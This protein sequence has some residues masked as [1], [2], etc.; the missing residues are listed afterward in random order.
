MRWT[1]RQRAMLR[2]MGVQV[3]SREPALV[4]A[5]PADGDEAEATSARRVSAAAKATAAAARS[6]ASPSSPPSPKGTDGAAVTA[7]DWLVVGDPLDPNDPQQELLLDNLLRAIGVSRKA[8]ARAGRAVFVDDPADIAA[9]IAS[10]APRCVIAL[11]RG[12][13]TA[14]LGRDEPVG[15]WRGR[16]HRHGDVPVVVTFALAF[17]LRHPA[18]KAKAWLDLC[19]AVGAGGPTDGAES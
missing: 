1:E 15:A 7:A 13:A 11:G 6:P 14:L 3:W 10:V 8:T 17:L 19:L 4:E 2:E 18:E 12:A 16:S 5:G 9:A